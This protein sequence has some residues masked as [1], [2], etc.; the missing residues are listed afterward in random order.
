MKL[1]HPGPKKPAGELKTFWKAHDAG[2]K[3]DFPPSQVHLSHNLYRGMPPWFNAF[4][5]YFQSR[6]IQ[7]WARA[8]RIE[9][10][11]V[12]LDIGCG[13]GRWIEFMLRR[14]QK[15]VG[16]DLGFKALGYAKAH[17]GPAHYVLGKLPDL[18]FGG[19]TFHWAVSVT[20]LQHLP[21]ADQ[22]RGLQEVHR[23]LKPG[24]YLMLCESIDLEDRSDY[25][26]A[27]SLLQWR[28]QVRQAGFE[29]LDQRG[30][31]FL[32]F[33]KGFHW[34]RDRVLPPTVGQPSERLMV[35]S[36]AAYLE[37]RPGLAGLLRILWGI[38]Y[39]GE[40][41]AGWLFPKRWARLGCFLLRK[42]SCV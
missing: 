38:S 40:F 19:E 25:L 14:K 23:V 6:I 41:L 16:I 12:S 9:P 2:L 4:F 34:V 18:G 33:I 31:E 22:A 30:C 20:V 21:P 11:M 27:N 42:G 17:G 7:S 37:D 32:P 29:I 39:P 15:A 13:T 3:A 35:S 28:T 26:F 10:A 36:V 5:N 1:P 24:G 8:C